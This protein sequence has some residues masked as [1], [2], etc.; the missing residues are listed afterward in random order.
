MVSG[1]GA[2]A[3][4]GSRHHPTR[5]AS[6]GGGWSAQATHPAAR[7]RTMAQTVTGLTNHSTRPE[8]AGRLAS[9]RF[10]SGRRV[11]SGVRPLVDETLSMGATGKS[12]LN[13]CNRKAI[14]K[15]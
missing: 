4:A 7:G 14:R 2:Q 6:G 15:L 5:V 11:S 1:G 13:D 12:N 10:A 9:A 3:V 8:P